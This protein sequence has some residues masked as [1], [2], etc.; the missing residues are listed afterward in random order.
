MNRTTKK[1]QTQYA[2]RLLATT[3]STAAA[4]VGARLIWL[5]KTDAYLWLAMGITALAGI[6][7][8]YGTVDLCRRRKQL[9]QLSV[10]RRHG[11]YDVRE[12]VSPQDAARQL[13]DPDGPHIWA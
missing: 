10:L 13:G 4:V 1:L 12:Y 8:F 2:T 11:P 6:I 5:G 3:A 7:A 9:K